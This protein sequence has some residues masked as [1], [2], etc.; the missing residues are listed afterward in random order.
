[1]DYMKMIKIIV[2]GEVM[3]V[4]ADTVVSELLQNLGISDSKGVAIAINEE[5]V[6]KSQWSAKMFSPDDQ[7]IIIKATAG[8]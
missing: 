4:D 6:P 7:M 5:V 1:M 2:N 8:G 3:H